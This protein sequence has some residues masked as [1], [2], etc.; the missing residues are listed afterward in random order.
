MDAYE[1]PVDVQDEGIQFEN[2]DFLYVEQFLKT[3]AATS[4]LDY[5][6]RDIDWHR[7]SVTMFGTRY[8]VPRL[9]AWYADSDCAYRYSG[10]TRRGEPWTECL[11]ENCALVKRRLHHPFN[12]LLANRYRSGSDYVG[13]HSDDERDMGSRPVIASLSLGASRV[14]RVRPR[15]G[16]KSKSLLLQHGSLLVMWGDSQGFFKHSVPKTAQRVGERINLTY[17]YVVQ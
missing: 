8:R 10:T 16:G 17:R 7:E 13:W 1:P 5:C 6:L 14:F 2:Q 4:L 11:A 15:S 12:F 9:T 3:T